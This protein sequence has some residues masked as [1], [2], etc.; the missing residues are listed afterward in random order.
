MWNRKQLVSW[1]LGLAGLGLGVLVFNCKNANKESDYLSLP[2]LAT[3][4]NGEH[5]V[6]S[7]T[8]MG[9]HADIYDSYLETAHYNTSSVADTSTVKGSFMVG[10]N[11]LDLADVSFTMTQEGDSLFQYIKIRNRS[12]ALPPTPFDVV[13]GSGVRGQSYLSWEENDLYQLQ[14]SYHS[15]SDNWVN[16]PGYPSYHTKRPIRSAC[17]KCHVTHAEKKGESVMGNSFDRSKMILG[18]SCEKCHGP[19]LKHVAYQ[20]KHPEAGESKFV[21]KID[22]LLRQQRLDLCAQCH[23][24]PRDVQLKG[25]AFSYFTGEDLNQHSRNIDSGKPQET[26]D[27]HGNQYGLLIQSECFKETPTMDC[28]TCHNPHKKERGDI[29]SFIL[30]CIA[31]HGEMKK[32]YSVDAK[33]STEMQ[34]NCISCH[35]PSKPSKAMMVQLTPDSVETSFKIRS[36][37]IGI[38]AESLWKE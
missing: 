20:Q 18:I 8:C 36:H 27:V 2:I 23:S 38:Y 30:K 13:V 35:M 5:Y 4:A 22:T 24:G 10:A 12:I 32:H 25:D 1:I 33:L 31:C 29:A 26:L 9:C 17:L 14:V 16:S 6:G 15:Q 34:D 28:N 11:S 19:S 21:I 3:H 37:L 7:K